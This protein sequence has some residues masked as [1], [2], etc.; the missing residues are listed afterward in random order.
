MPELKKGKAANGQG[1]IEKI[2]V[3]LKNEN[4]KILEMGIALK[5]TYYEGYN[6]VK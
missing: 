5:N 2:D 1:A 4:I 6:L 3:E